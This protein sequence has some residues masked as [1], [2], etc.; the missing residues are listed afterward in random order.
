VWLLEQDLRDPE[1]YLKVVIALN[2][3]EQPPYA[4]QRNNLEV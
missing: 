4:M 3:K 2:Y 1:E